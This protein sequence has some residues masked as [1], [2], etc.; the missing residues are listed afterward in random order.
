MKFSVFTRGKKLLFLSQKC[1]GLWWRT[2][3]TQSHRWGKKRLLLWQKKTCLMKT[4][5]WNSGLIA[6]TKP[7]R[8]LWIIK[9]L[10]QSP[11]VGLCWINSWS[12][13]LLILLFGIGLE[14]LTEVL[15][16]KGYSDYP[17]PSSKSVES[18]SENGV[19]ISQENT[20]APLCSQM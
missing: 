10:K 13:I 16:E 17:H 6:W 15:H 2:S 9:W 18:F 4:S 3:F 14:S 8:F 12:G 11:F 5:H 1:P 20:S 19:Q 7:G